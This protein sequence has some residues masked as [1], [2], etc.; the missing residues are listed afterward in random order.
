MRIERLNRVLGKLEAMGI[1][2][3]II[4]DPM[5]IFYLTDYSIDPGERLFAFYISKNGN[6]KLF[7]NHLF[8][9]PGNL[10]VELVRFSDTDDYVSMLCD[11]VDKDSPLGVDKLL[12]AKFLLPLIKSCPDTPFELTSVCVDEV[13]A[14]K[15]TEE[16]ERMR[17]A[18]RIN[19]QAMA[20]FKLLLKEGVTEKEVAGKMLDIYRSLGGDDLS[21]SPIVSFGTN[22]A[23]GHHEPDDTPLK[24]GDAVILDVGC[25]KDSYCSDMTRAFFFKKVADPRHKEIYDTIRKA[26]AAAEAVCKPGVPLWQID[27]AARDVIAGAGYGEY[28]KRRTGHFIGLEV[29]DYGDVSSANQNLTQ[30]GNV[31]SIE[32][33]IN[34]PGEIGI[35]IE[36]LVMI[37]E[38]GCEILNHYTHE[39]QILE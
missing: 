10:G 17:I 16:R 3:M 23:I 13:R 29:H 30:P 37:T 11:A 1:S 7:V 22:T 5:S 12:P 33:G 8:A 2:Q 39:L 9:V 21:F 15:D 27:K 32:P 6:H 14:C 18:S 38:D 24:E 19:D 26:V 34:I 36:D 28:F 31:F 4:S 35:Y 20:Q 25:R